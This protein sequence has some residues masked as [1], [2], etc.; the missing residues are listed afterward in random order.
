M[1][2]CAAT[3]PLMD[4]QVADDEAGWNPSTLS[5][6]PLSPRFHQCILQTAECY[7][8]AH[9]GFCVAAEHLSVSR[10]SYLAAAKPHLA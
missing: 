3:E 1:R 5:P 10:G 7:V 4:L 2:F 6:E 9:D 8:T